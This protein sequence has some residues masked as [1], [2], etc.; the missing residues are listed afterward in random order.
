MDMMWQAVAA[1][2]GWNI[3]A[4][5]LFAFVVVVA[6]G[7]FHLPRAIRQARCRHERYF[8]NGSCHAI[9]RDCRKDL[10][11]IGTWRDKLEA[12]KAA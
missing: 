12:E 5:L 10:G 7:L 9:C 4:P 2:F 3:V 6:V 1:W 8:E 11:F